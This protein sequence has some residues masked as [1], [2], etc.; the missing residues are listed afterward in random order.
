MNLARLAHTDVN[1]A[2]PPVRGASPLRAPTEAAAAGQRAFDGLLWTFRNGFEQELARLPAAAW[3]DPARQG[4]RRV[5]ANGARDVWQARI[6]AHDYFLKYYACSRWTDKLKSRLRGP[7]CLTEWNGGVYA[8]QAG[9]AA[10]RPAGFTPQLRYGGQAC[11]LLVTEALAGAVPLNAFWQT[12]CSDTDARRRRADVAIL[13]E[14]VADLIACAHQSG[15]EHLDMHAENIL[16]R[17]VGPR[18]Y[19][20]VFVDLQSARLGRP[21]TD[22][23]VVRNLAQLNQWFRRNSPIGDRIRFLRSYFRWRNDYETAFAHARPLGLSFDG[24]VRALLQAARRHAERLW[25]RRDRRAFRDG[26]YF[27]RL[28]CG[29]GWRA[30]AFVRCKHELAGSA[31]TRRALSATWWR[32]ALI[33]PL[34][35]FGPGAKLS[36]R[37]HSATVAR[38]ALSHP[39]GALEVIA[40]RPLARN[41]MRGLRGLLPRSRSARGWRTGYALLN[42]DI[43]AARPLALLERR[44]GPLVLDSILL[45]E[46]VLGGR[47]LAETLRNPPPSSSGRAAL[48]WKI[49]LGDVLVTHL[50]R[51]HERGFVHRDCKAQNI[52][53][54]EAPLRAVW[55][56]MDGIR[57]RRPRPADQQR[58]LA[59]LEESLRDVPG[60]HR[61]DRVRFLK[62]YLSIWGAPSDAWRTALRSIGALADSKAVAKGLRRVWKKRRY[63]RE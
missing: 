53:I 13:I 30:L 19:R 47:D 7:A 48:R 23:A 45:T 52:L 44:I 49:A 6:G 28:R 37:S 21:V 14:A 15:F 63:G 56:D 39:E 40:K 58:A 24:L 27:A 18:Q 4:W 34:R 60:L 2:T 41:L 55:I 50:R 36:K 62:R 29:G 31:V 46:V 1:A 20:A 5:K 16:V 25:A 57:R 3:C 42:R 12:L 22:A 59:R 35:W 33:N 9:V 43:A 32:T 26:R 17:T 54:C 10:V 51:L 11:S 8:L 61:T 38:V